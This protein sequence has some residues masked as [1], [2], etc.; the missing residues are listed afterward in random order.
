MGIILGSSE[1][2]QFMSGSDDGSGSFNSTQEMGRWEVDLDDNKSVRLRIISASFG[3]SSDNFPFYYSGS[4]KIGIGT[5]DP[6]NDVDIKANSFKIRSDDGT[7]ELEFTQEGKLITKEFGTSASGSELLL[8]FD[9]G[10]F[11]EEL[12]VVDGDT[13]GT[14]RWASISGSDDDIG[15]VG[16]AATIHVDARDAISGYP[17]GD[18]IFSTA[19]DGTFPVTELLRIGKGVVPEE[20]TLDG[21]ILHGGQGHLNIQGNSYFTGSVRIYNTLTVDSNISSNATCSAEHYTGTPIVLE[22][23]NIYASS[24]N[25][26]VP[27][28]RVGNTSG[29]EAGDWNQNVTSRTAPTANESLYALY[30]PFKMKNVSAKVSAKSQAGGSPSFWMYTGSRP[31]G[32]DAFDLGFAASA[33][34]GVVGA[35]NGYYNMD[36]TGSK[37]FNTRS[38]DDALFIYIGN[39]TA[40]TDTIRCTAVIYGEKA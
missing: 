21:M 25:G 29:I 34:T 28:Y 32:T 12:G 2:I 3:G 39:D 15:T 22:H 13:L 24:V 4:G 8:T 36:I 11:G 9:R 14:I 5:I 10:N 6:K 20:P 1:A 33:S 23:L 27:E 40:A 37:S 26:A 16:T 38:E 30:L 35:S 17:G 18:I 31:N 7:K 19:K